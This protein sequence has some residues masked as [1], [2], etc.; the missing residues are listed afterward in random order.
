[1]GILIWG[2]RPAA[3][4]QSLAC[5]QDIHIN[6]ACVTMVQKHGADMLLVKMMVLQKRSADPQESLRA[7]VIQTL[8]GLAYAGVMSA[9]MVRA[10]CRVI[11]DLAKCAASEWDMSMYADSALGAAGVL[12]SFGLECSKTQGGCLRDLDVHAGVLERL[13]QC[14]VG[15]A[16]DAKDKTGE[17]KQH[18][19]V[20]HAHVLCLAALAELCTC[21]Q[22]KSALVQCMGGACVRAV[23]DV[24][25]MEGEHGPARKVLKAIAWS[26][27]PKQDGK[28]KEIA[29]LTAQGQRVYFA[30]LSVESQN[31]AQSRHGS[32]SDDDD[33]DD[34]WVCA[35]KKLSDAGLGKAI[36]GH[37]AK[38]EL[39][40][41]VQGIWVSM[42]FAC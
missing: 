14:V 20:Q 6:E 13:I 17:P 4:L 38:N 37:V 28:E 27:A 10:G 11:F 35:A 26:V 15:F 33:D 18:E 7:H 42:L 22:G 29:I 19:R 1:M 5:G 39:V 31:D 41:Q 9:D 12:Y 2:G 16:C 3:C 8:S 23:L 34:D 32:K 30:H 21:E 24:A 25:R 40:L 36:M